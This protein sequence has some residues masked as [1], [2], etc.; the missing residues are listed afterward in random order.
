M[1]DEGIY[2]RVGTRDKVLFEDKVE[3]FSSV[4]EEGAFDVLSRHANFVSLIRK[5]IVI[6]KLD[7]K[8]EE[9]KINGDGV[10]RVVK[11][12]AEAFLGIGE[13]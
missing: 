12:K 5:S 11:N 13:K 7:G 4:N 6:R 2:L 10:L 1:A 8:K 3:S 9:I